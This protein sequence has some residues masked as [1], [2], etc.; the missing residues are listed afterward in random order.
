MIVNYLK[1]MQTNN[2]SFF[3]AI[4]VDNEDCLTTVFWVDARSR[5][6]YSYIGDA[7]TVTQTYIMN[8]YH[9]PLVTFIG[10]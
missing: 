8:R 3:Y 10:A 6:G 2:P 5:M 4:Q 1:C 9:M 7:L